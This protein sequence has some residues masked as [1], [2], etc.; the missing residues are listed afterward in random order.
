MGF[1]NRKKIIELICN[2]PISENE[3]LSMVE[4]VCKFVELTRITNIDKY[5]F[6]DKELEKPKKLK[7]EIKLLC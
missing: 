1:R 3:L 4:T 2:Y 6:E 5:L 7:K